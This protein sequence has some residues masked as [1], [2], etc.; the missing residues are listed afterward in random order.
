[1]IGALILVICAYLLWRKCSARHK[2]TYVLE[3]IVKILACIGLIT[4]EKGENKSE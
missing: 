4:I 1:V 3:E 2:G